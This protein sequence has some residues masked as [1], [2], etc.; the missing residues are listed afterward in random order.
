MTTGS[1][2][3]GAALLLLTALYVARPFLRTPSANERRSLH[4][5]KLAAKDAIVDEIRRLEFDHDTGKIPTE[6]FSAERAKLVRQAAQ[7]LQELDASD[8]NSTDDVDD[9]IERAIAALRET[10]VVAAPEKRG[11]PQHA[12]NFCPQC[13][14]SVQSDDKFCAY[15]GHKLGPAAAA[16]R[17]T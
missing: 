17:S 14:S 11:P 10:A 3:L 12:V 5:E 8:L 2:L 13:G 16:G 6:L 15:C 4:L 7:I 1:I 9:A